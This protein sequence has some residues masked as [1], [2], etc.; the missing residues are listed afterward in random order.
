MIVRNRL[1]QLRILRLQLGEAAL[2]PDHLVACTE[3][4]HGLTCRPDARDEST[5]VEKSAPKAIA[6]GA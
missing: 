5:T 4:E 6:L 3:Q 1:D 2:K